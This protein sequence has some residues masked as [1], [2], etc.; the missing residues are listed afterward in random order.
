[1]LL[2]VWCMMSFSFGVTPQFLFFNVIVFFQ[3]E[4]TKLN[5]F[6]KTPSP[7]A[8]SDQDFVSPPQTR[9]KTL[10]DRILSSNFQKQSVSL[11]YVVS[12]TLSPSQRQ[13]RRQ[14]LNR[15]PLLSTSSDLRD[16]RREMER[17]RWREFKE[18]TYSRSLSL[19]LRMKR[20][21][22]TE[23]SSEPSKDHNSNG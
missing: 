7:G 4:R 16:D 10:G 21:K 18:K 12:T 22:Q 5:Y 23:S 17:Q 15:T 19:H 6:N 1:M 2:V 8:S 9:N 20:P 11:S 3:R 13:D 14:S